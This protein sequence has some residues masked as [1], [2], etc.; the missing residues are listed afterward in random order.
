MKKE[1]ISFIL[2][3]LVLCTVAYSQPAEPKTAQKLASNWLSINSPDGYILLEQHMILD[4]KEN[5]LAFRHDLHPSGY[6]VVSN[7][8]NLPPVIAYSF[9]SAYSNSE[10]KN[11]PLQEL[12]VA[13]MTSRYDYLPFMRVTLK[14]Q[15]QQLWND[16][17]REPSHEASFEQWPPAGSTITGGWVET[18]WKQSAPYNNFC[19]LDNVTGN[20]SI[21]G[22]PA[23]ALAMIIHYQKNLNGTQFS[24]GDDY[25]HNYAGRQYWIDD[26]SH[27]MEF[28]PF[29]EINTFFDSIAKR[30]ISYT[31]LNTDEMAALVFA[32]GVAAKQVFTSEVSGTFGVD[33]AYDAYMRFGF[34]D[35]SLIYDSDTSF[36]THMKNNMKDGI[37]V[38]LA[39]LVDGAGGGHNVVADG[40]NTDDY[41]HLNFGWGG[42][43]NGWYLVPEEIPYNL[44]IVEG[45]I[46]DI[47]ESHVGIKLPSTKKESY[48]SLYP[49]PSKGK[50]NISFELHSPAK[51]KI[52]L[53][54]QRG[55]ILKV[56]TEGNLYSGIHQFYCDDILEAGIY[57]ILVDLED[58]NLSKKIIIIN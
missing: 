27:S 45:A 35:A 15:N 36:Y 14:E 1:I 12:L 48:L 22:C 21:A 57:N 4:S 43:Y 42:S 33:Q 32:C 31:P 23:V 52:L 19:P 47:G 6:I 17:L 20:R 18:N 54:D 30:F 5:I 46:M 11:N 41:Y 2:T 50:F 51:A 24:D 56:I 9:S 25:Y 44:T 10:Y 8:L 49:N 26:D 28:P 13:D 34:G 37:P 29:P 16:L 39:L 38:H 58:H 55:A 3:W 40:Y 7:D 53:C